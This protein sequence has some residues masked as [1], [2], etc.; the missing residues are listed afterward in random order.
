MG[1]QSQSLLAP[2][3]EEPSQVVGIGGKLRLV[4]RNLGS[5]RSAVVVFGE[6]LI[7]TRI[8]RHR[9]DE[10]V[11]RVPVGAGTGTVRVVTGVDADALRTLQA[12]ITSLEDATNADDRERVAVL[13]ETIRALLRRGSSSEARQI[14]VTAAYVKPP[15]ADRVD[16]APGLSIVK[17]RIIVDLEDT[18]G[19]ETALALGD[20]YGLS[21][22]GYFPVTNSFV[23]DAATALDLSELR[24][25]GRLLVR[26][27]RV[28]EYWLDLVCELK[29]VRF[30]DADVVNRYQH[31]YKPDL[32]GREDV[33]A[34]DRIQAPAAW[35]LIERF[36]GRDRLSP[37]KLAVLDSGCDQRHAE[38]AGVTLTKVVT[39][40]LRLKI[41]GR[42]VILPDAR[43]IREIPYADGD[44]A[45]NHGTAVTSLI[46]ARNDNVLDA[47]QNDR[48]MNGMLH[49]PMPYTIQIYQ[50]SRFGSEED[51]FPT[52]EF[53]AA[54]NG[55]AITNARI[56]NASF[57][58]P[59]PIDPDRSRYRD[60][61]RVALRK[62]AH[63]LNQ[64]RDRVLLVVA[65]GNEANAPG[66]MRG[67]I[68]PFEDINL[69]NHLDTGEDL[70][71]DCILDAGNYVAASLGT[72]PNVITVGAI[73]GPI[74]SD[75]SHDD[76]RAGFSNWGI[77]VEIAAPGA[78]V[79]VAGGNG[80]RIGG[81]RFSFW[82]GTSFATPLVTGT[83]ALLRGLR[84]SLTPEQLKDL[85]L[86]TSLDIVTE[87]GRGGV[88]PWKTLKAGFAVRQ[89]L[90]DMGR[91]T[92]DQEW[93]GVS[94]IVFESNLRLF[95]AE[96]RRGPNGRAEL[97]G[98]RP[99]DT[100][101]R[102]PT[103]K[104]DGRWVAFYDSAGGR[105]IVDAIRFD[106]GDRITLVGPGGERQAYGPLLE[107]GPGGQLMWNRWTSSEDGCTQR[108]EVLVLEDGAANSVVIADTGDHNTC[109]FDAE[110]NP[111]PWKR[112]D[113]HRAIWVPN[114]REWE[115]SY[116]YAEGTGERT[117]H[118]CD[119]T[120]WRKNTFPAAVR[121]FP[122]CSDGPF[123]LP[124][125]AP[126]GRAQGGGQLSRDG[127]IHIETVFYDR[128]HGLLF[129]RRGT[130][131]QALLWCN[132][133]PDGSEF[134]VLEFRNSFFLST[135]RRD[136]RDVGDRAIRNVLR[137]D[138][139]PS[140][141]TWSW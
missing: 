95:L 11:V 134:A 12:E 60:I 31:R 39:N 29:Q 107:F 98:S 49:N 93:T 91:I 124:S 21:L 4:G 122:R 66:T 3:V 106:R 88:M 118:S 102:H 120:W 42:E 78:H 65:A 46:G 80:L 45:S 48:G 63:Q 82:S 23:F 30:V 132:W 131:T 74:V 62:I 108:A 44:T 32:G 71:G 127:L 50:T 103:L 20:R 1:G 94:K 27:W 100:R 72:L 83:A 2:Q 7:A 136:Y 18:E 15:P 10:I 64:F 130:P 47:R 137:I 73:G 90:L 126:D 28:R 38:F 104:Q 133:S 105:S 70:D 86:R 56:I 85:I 58:Q 55:A 34:T 51:K 57:G 54:I 125:W 92:N 111:L 40:E 25:L 89:V 43:S 79:F 19:F 59:E 114:G 119:N 61:V 115:I 16:D 69:N 109:P 17:G 117:T 67:L 128:L 101:G 14:V 123:I 68:T 113:L 112:Y 26:D 52:T 141:F 6:S 24:G 41:A 87:D 140:D 35:N 96:V 139:Q 8:E 22:V 76:Q 53:L 84:P 110:R 97:F 75:W 138:G 36:V 121:R 33:Y 37:V 77:P 13:E 116:S 129:S 9:S 5:S 99:L 135:I 81:Q